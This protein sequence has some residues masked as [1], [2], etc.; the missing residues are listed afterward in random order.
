[1]AGESS[2]ALNPAQHKLAL[3]VEKLQIE[4]AALRKP[5]ARWN[6]TSIVAVLT[7]AGTLVGAGFQYKL[8]QIK[9]EQTALDLTRLESKHAEVQT[10]LASA[11][12]NLESTTKAQQDAKANLDQTLQQLADAE[13]ALTNAGPGA[14][15][16]AFRA[17]I[18]QARASLGA[19]SASVER[20]S[21]SVEA[22]LT[23]LQTLQQ[24]MRASAP[25]GLNS[26]KVGVYF[27]A[28]SPEGRRRA[29]RLRDT[30]TG[31][32]GSVELYSW[33]IRS[34]G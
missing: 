7:V 9:A 17:A 18:G 21:T 11:I 3:E 6:L 19:V 16:A 2:D 33:P 22:D 8:N 27:L 15:S 31:V 28:A 4:V 1:M 26:V 23:R 29:E 34:N 10:L 12:A 20:S 13:A 14:Q 24:G 25:A 32:A 30:L 5:T